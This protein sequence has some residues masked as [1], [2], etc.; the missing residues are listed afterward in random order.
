MVE[1]EDV[2]G[3]T[4]KRPFRW[5]LWPSPAHESAV[6]EVLLRESERAFSLYGAIDEQQPAFRSIE[7]RFH[8]R[9]LGSEALGDVDDLAA[10]LQRFLAVGADALL[11]QRA[12]LAAITDID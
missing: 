9:P 8:G 3:D 6:I 4:Q 7:L 1:L 2:G 11:L 5:Y 10:L 12:A